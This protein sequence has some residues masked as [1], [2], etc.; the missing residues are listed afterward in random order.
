MVTTPTTNWLPG[1]RI[2]WLYIHESGL[3]SQLAGVV[4]EVRP[5]EVR[6]RVGYRQFISRKWKVFEHSVS[7]TRL[8]ARDTTVPE[9]DNHA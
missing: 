2:T 9:V 1:D 4:L 7:P 3:T 6:V 8:I 5:R